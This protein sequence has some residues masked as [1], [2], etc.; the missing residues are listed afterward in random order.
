MNNENKIKVSLYKEKNI[1]EPVVTD[2]PSLSAD[3]KIKVENSI[4]LF[5][6][7]LK[8]KHS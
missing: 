6:D 2:V 3:K 7:L 5:F 8:N 4:K 1:G